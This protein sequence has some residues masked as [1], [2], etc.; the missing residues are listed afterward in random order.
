[1]CVR[2]CVCACVRVCVCVCVYE[3][4]MLFDMCRVRALSLS[5]YTLIHIYIYMHTYVHVYVHTHNIY[6]TRH[7]VALIHTWS[8]DI[9]LKPTLYT[10]KTY[11]IYP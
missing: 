3:T 7:L 2:V 5:R 6:H 1:V 11:F 10:L 9:P 8:Y 4:L